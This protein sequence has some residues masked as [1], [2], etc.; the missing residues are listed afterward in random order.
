MS[1]KAWQGYSKV[2]DPGL[3]RV[4]SML[5]K[6]KKETRYPKEKGNKMILLG[7]WFKESRNKEIEIQ[8]DGGKKLKSY[9]VP[10]WASIVVLL[11]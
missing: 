11:V 6:Y 4:K 10:E 9:W 2:L 5:G 3:L 7:F 8:S 1:K